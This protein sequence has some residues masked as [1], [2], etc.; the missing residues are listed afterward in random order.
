MKRLSRT[1]VL[2]QAFHTNFVWGQ[3]FLLISLSYQ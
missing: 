2:S 3:R 1:H